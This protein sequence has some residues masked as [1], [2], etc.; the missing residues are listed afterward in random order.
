M[1]TMGTPFELA[2]HQLAGVA[3]DGGHRVVRNLG[4]GHDGGR[5]DLIR[6]VAEAGAQDQRDARPDP[7]EAAKRRGPPRRRARP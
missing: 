2:Q 7:A 4:V 3:G 5:R 6:Q 1:A